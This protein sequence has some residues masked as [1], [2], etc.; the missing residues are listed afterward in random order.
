[1]LN[2]QLKRL[3]CHVHGTS[4]Q[5]NITAC[6]VSFTTFE[7]VMG[8]AS[9]VIILEVTRLTTHEHTRSH[10]SLLTTL[11]FLDCVWVAVSTVC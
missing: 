2:M 5:V 3:D 4:C 1:M 7:M 11:C 6:V 9:N 10:D 8:K